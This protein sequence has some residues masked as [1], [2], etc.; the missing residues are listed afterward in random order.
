VARQSDCEDTAVLNTLDGFSIDPRLS[1]P[2]DGTINVATANSRT[3][4][5]LRLCT[6]GEQE[7]D[8]DADVLSPAKSAPIGINQIVWDTLTNTLHVQ[9]GEVLEQHTRYA[10]I[11]TSGLRDV[12]GREV[13]ASEAFRRFRRSGRG[14]YREELIQGIHAAQRLGIPVNQIVTGA[15]F[16]T[17]STTALLEKVR[18]QIKAAKPEAA[19]FA[20][21]PGGRHTIFPLD[22]VNG[23]TWDQQTGDSP[24]SFTRLVLNLPLLQ[25]I[26]GA[27]GSVA[28]GRYRSPDYEMHPG[29]FIPP[30]GTR[31]GTPEVQATDDIYFNLV[32]PSGKKPD[33]GWPVA[34]VGHGNGNNKNQFLLNVAGSMA[35]QGIATIAI[36]NMGAGFG[37]LGTITVD[38]REG[39][40]VAFPSGGRGIDQNQ[41]GV[42]ESNEGC[43]A[44]RPRAL[45]FRTDCIRQTV[46][47]MMQLVRV[48]EVG[49]D[50]DGDGVPD[51][52]PSRIYYFG[53]SFGGTTGMLLAS[54]EPALRAADFSVPGPPF[55]FER[56]SPTSRS[57]LGQMLAARVPSLINA[58]GVTNLGGVPVAAP[59]F[60]ENFPLRDG[61]PYP[62]LLAD[63]TAREIRSP[64]INR[65]PGAMDIQEVVART[66]WLGCSAD[67]LTYAP[68]LRRSPL[69]R[70]SVKPVIIQYGTGDQAVP[71]PNI[72]AIVRAADLADVTTFYRHDLAFA[73]DP[74]LPR[75]PHPFMPAI[76]NPSFREISLGAQE[77]IAVFLASDGTQIIHPE[78]QRFFEVPIVP[79]LPEDLGFIP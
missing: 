61:I 73:E 8:C 13:E 29:E 35:A 37:P 6:E 32:V 33:T 18:D 56:L 52:D 62:V 57:Q 63:G 58:P 14:P 9:S 51:L 24:P 30:V 77:Q 70:V 68:H 42:I 74:T 19:D 79:P 54:I 59:H 28:F 23:I 60:D 21:G 34:I 78:P 46:A 10:L 16:T 67:P 72:T 11:V 41:D 65:V 47:D 38:R 2:F 15:V 7:N 71:N 75:N 3:V 76:D 22:S 31:T 55:S 26:P 4:F 50:F 27:V 5:L 36:N 40:P 48:I 39:E 12:E 1:I 44:A 49:V 17:Q 25:I 20:L 66:I 43:A 53:N 64:V 45:I 69:P